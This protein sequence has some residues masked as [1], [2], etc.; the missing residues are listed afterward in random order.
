MSAQKIDT[1]LSLFGT[2]GKISERCQLISYN[3]IMQYHFSYD[4]TQKANIPETK[5][6]LQIH[7]SVPGFQLFRRI[8]AIHLLLF[9][10]A[11]G[12]L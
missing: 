6:L 11:F 1:V 8:A 5:W 9:S 7:V 12:S 2:L 10:L 4:F 3:I